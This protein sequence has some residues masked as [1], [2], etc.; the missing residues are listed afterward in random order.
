MRDQLDLDETGDG[1]LPAI[2]FER[3]VVLEQG[4]GLGPAIE[5]AVQG[6]A[7][8][9]EDAIHGAGALGLEPS[10]GVGSAGEALG[11]PGES[12]RQQ[13]FE[14]VRPGIAGRFPDCGER[15]VDGGRIER[16][17]TPPIRRRGGG[18]CVKARMAPFRV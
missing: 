5:M 12:Q 9:V 6:L 11:S 7:A 17:S 15:G 10:D 4:A 2:D 3:D 8:V 13:G 18:G 1:D 14:A 16:W